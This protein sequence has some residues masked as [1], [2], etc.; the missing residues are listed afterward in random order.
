[1][2]RCDEATHRSHI[3][4][5]LLFAKRKTNKKIMR[6]QPAANRQP[7]VFIYYCILYMAQSKESENLP[8]FIVLLKVSVCVCDASERAKRATLN[9]K[10]ISKFYRCHSQYAPIY[11]FYC[12]PALAGD[13][14]N[15]IHWIG[16]DLNGNWYVE[17]KLNT[18]NIGQQKTVH[19][20][21]CVCAC[22]IVENVFRGIRWAQLD[23]SNAFLSLA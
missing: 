11:L 10:F 2:A 3:S 13:I 6:S 14:A 21:V 12:V 22:E 7:H 4:R 19:D 16:F 9:T 1:M 20:C 8:I 23:K 15:T 18:T 17:C 5:C